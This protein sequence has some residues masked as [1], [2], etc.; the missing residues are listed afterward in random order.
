VSPPILTFLSDFGEDDWFVGVV[1]G[2]I[3]EIC[4]AARVVDL[5]HRVPPGDVARAAFILEAAAPDFPAGTIHMAVVDP[6]VGTDRRA[7]AVRARGQT[8][9][10]PDNGVL[11]WALSDP[12]AEV[13]S[14]GEPRYFRHPVSRTFHGRDVFAPVAAHLGAGVRHEQLGPRVSDPMRTPRAEPSF[15]G[16]TL[17][18]RVVFVDHFGN[19]LTDLT[20]AALGRAFASVAES[21]LEVRV[22]GSVVHGITR[23]YGDD[24]IGTL[25]AILGSSGR[26]E[27]AEVGGA[28]SSRWGIG[29]GDRIEVRATR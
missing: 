7:L 15:D 25:V 3:A 20:V 21:A 10:G 16:Q 18:G 17:N 19:A 1:H 26:L 2:V 29:P 27:L 6:G 4:P 24:P 11:E 8:F 22:H 23:S 13:R 12:E 14:L 28:A 5:T 9:V